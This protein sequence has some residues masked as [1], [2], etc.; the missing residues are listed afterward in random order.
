MDFKSPF[1][2]PVKNGWKKLVFLDLS[3]DFIQENKNE[4]ILIPIQILAGVSLLY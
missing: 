1:H 2:I 4:M 3:I